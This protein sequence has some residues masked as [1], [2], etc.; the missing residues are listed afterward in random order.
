M[1]PA[2]QG[3]RVAGE[4]GDDASRGPMVDPGTVRS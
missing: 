4:G 2:A 1:T 3:G